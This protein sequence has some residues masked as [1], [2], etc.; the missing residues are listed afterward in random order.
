MSDVTTPEIVETTV[1]EEMVPEF[2]VNV[3]S[4]EITKSRVIAAVRALLMLITSVASMFGFAFDVDGVYQ[5]VLVVLMAASMIWGYWKNN[6]WTQKAV[7]AQDVTRFKPAPD[8]ALLV[9]RNTHGSPDEAM[10]I[11]DT[12]YDIAM[13]RAAGC[14]TCGVTYGNHSA[15]RLLAAGADHVISSFDALAEICL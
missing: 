14:R 9:L 13:G 10:V 6:N 12:E 11:G 3:G 4:A 7:A 1:T 8:M 2:T 5:L 15:E